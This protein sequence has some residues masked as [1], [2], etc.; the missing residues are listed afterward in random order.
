MM[1][2]KRCGEPGPLDEA[3]FCEECAHDAIGL[4]SGV[5]KTA[6]IVAA[7][8]ESTAVYRSIKEMPP[9]LRRKL[10]RATNSGNSGTILIADKR[11]RQEVARA[12]RKLPK[13]LRAAET[14]PFWNARVQQCVAMLLILCTVVL[15]FLVFT[16]RF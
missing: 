4:A 15:I 6:T 8:G 12:L 14:S 16:N 1:H 2:C 7:V 13:A 9:Q 10:R 5:V 11:G 3:G